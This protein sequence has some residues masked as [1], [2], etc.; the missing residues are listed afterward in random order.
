VKT[1]SGQKGASEEDKKYLEAGMV[2]VAKLLHKA[3]GVDVSNIPGAGSDSS[4]LVNVE[5]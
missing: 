3:T 2:H 4:S 5:I 1:F